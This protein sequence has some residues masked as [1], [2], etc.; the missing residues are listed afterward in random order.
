MLIHRS[1]IEE[2]EMDLLGTCNLECP[3]CTRNY[4]HA[5]HML[6]PNTRPLK[7]IIRQLDT[8]PNLKRTF[9]AGAISEPTLHPE[10][11]DYLRYLK[12]R[13]IYVELFTNGSTHNPKYWKEVA[14]ILDDTDQV[15]FTICGSTQE[16]H[17]KYRVN[18]SLDKILE[19]AKALRSIKEIDYC[20]FIRFEYNKDDYENVLQMPFTFCYKVE[21]EGIRRLNDKVKEVPD[22]VKPLENR[23]KIIKSLF[24][25][26]PKCG[27]IACKSLEDK[28][29][30]IDQFGNIS[31]CYIHKE[32]EPQHVFEG[33]SFDY[34]SILA[35][36][37]K[38]CFLCEK[39]TRSLIEKMGLD[40]VC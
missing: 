39:R 31:A 27:E 28:K 18:S 13:D 33:E 24:K 37:Y 30:F 22:G 7:E 16:L 6:K 26:P 32:F 36:N 29:V 10:F 34:S 1:N 38:D 17:E 8:F 3:L 5:S 21:T 35:F 25:N 11:L 20:Q 9:C 15:H 2:F 19:N 12:S 40:F 4:T 14:E 23:D